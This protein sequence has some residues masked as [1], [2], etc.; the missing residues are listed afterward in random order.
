[1]YGTMCMNVTESR[2]R[3]QYGKV[4]MKDVRLL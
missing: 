3:C 1:M 2:F 4:K